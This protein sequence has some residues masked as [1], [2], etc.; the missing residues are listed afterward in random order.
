M[1]VLLKTILNVS[2]FF[3]TR[4]HCFIVRYVRLLYRMIKLISNERVKQLTSVNIFDESA[5]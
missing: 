1:N 3:Q 4:K 5:L 2:N